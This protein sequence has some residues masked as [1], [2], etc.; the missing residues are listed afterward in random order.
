M[1]DCALCCV[2]DSIP[3]VLL[4]LLQD[5]L[6]KRVHLFLSDVETDTWSEQDLHRVVSSAAQVIITQGEKGATLL[7]AQDSSS[8]SGSSSGGARSKSS[9]SSGNVHSTF[10]S[11]VSSRSDSSSKPF[12]DRKISAV[13]VGLQA[14]KHP[15]LACWH[16]LAACGLTVGDP[17]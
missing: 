4:P 1:A 13:K 8:S 7:S 12:L 16:C 17:P 11:T 9:S 5:G 2:V 6:S 3:A 15:L 14:M 10:G